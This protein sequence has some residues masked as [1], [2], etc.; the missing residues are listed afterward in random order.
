MS[1]QVEKPVKIDD[2]RTWSTYKVD[3][4]PE[5]RTSLLRDQIIYVLDNQQ[6]TGALWL[7]KKCPCIDWDAYIY[8]PRF[9]RKGISKV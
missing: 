8:N 6:D 4:L 2:L 7:N 9:I 1:K 3:L 5:G